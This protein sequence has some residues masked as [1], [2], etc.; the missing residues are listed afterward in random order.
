MTRTI[1]AAVLLLGGALN[2]QADIN[3]WVDTAKY[4][5]G[6]DALNVDARYCEDRVGQDMNGK[7]TTRRFKQCMAGC[8]WRF[9]HTT[10]QQVAPERTW[11]DPDTG[12]LCKDLKGSDGRAFGSYC[13]ND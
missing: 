1:L 4:P 13:S 7:P 2:A 10:R 3:H 6:N 9:D 12:L 11:I 5:R 8:G